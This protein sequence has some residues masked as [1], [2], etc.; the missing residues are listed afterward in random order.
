MARRAFPAG[1]GIFET[2]RTENAKVAELTRHMR[3][4]VR[5]AAHLEIPM[6]SED[7]IRSEINN[8]LEMNPHDVGR[9]RICIN[10]EGFSVTHD[11]YEDFQHPARVTFSSH[12]SLAEGEQFKTYPYESHYEILDNAA[13]YGFDDAIIFN[14]ENNVTET[15]ISNIALLIDSNWV[16]PPIGAGILPGVMRAIAIE[17]CGVEVRNIHITEFPHAQSA[18]LLSSLKIAQEVSHIGEQELITGARSRVLA[19]EM[20]QKVEFFSVG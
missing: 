10:K 7:A 16:T 15:A 3:R 18:I 5:A 19:Q 8:Q 12:T 2:L 20:R 6:P 9:L 11:P 4:A 1:E 17:R 14:R 13:L